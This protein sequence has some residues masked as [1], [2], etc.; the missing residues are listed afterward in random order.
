MLFSLT[1]EW[2][3]CILFEILDSLFYFTGLW[4][5]TSKLLIEL[6]EFEF[7]CSTSLKIEGSAYNFWGTLC[8]EATLFWETAWAQGKFETFLS[9]QTWSLVGGRMDDFCIWTGSTSFSVWY[10]D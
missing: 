3:D 2:E 4:F 6:F 8:F 7:D 5:V 1:W 10:S 9:V